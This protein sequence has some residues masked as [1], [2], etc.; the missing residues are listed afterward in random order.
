MKDAIEKLVANE[1]FERALRYIK[2]NLNWEEFSVAMRA[3]KTKEEFKSTLAY[4]AVMTVAKILLSRL[5]SQGVAVCRKIKAACTFIS[6]H[7]D[8]RIGCLLLD[9]CYMMWGYGYDAGRYRRQSF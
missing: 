8:Y 1:D 7:R 9:V 5:L 3:C 6:N 2:P 4:D